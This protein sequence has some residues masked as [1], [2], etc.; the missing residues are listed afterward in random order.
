MIFAALAAVVEGHQHGL[1]HRFWTWT[2]KPLFK[3]LFRSLPDPVFVK[4]IQA[5]VASTGALEPRPPS[6]KGPR[7]F[8]Y[9]GE[10]TGNPMETRAA[11]ATGMSESFWH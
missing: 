8:Q 7:P 3:L 5:G 1:G 11:S 2:G 6:K 9:S 4:I 10:K